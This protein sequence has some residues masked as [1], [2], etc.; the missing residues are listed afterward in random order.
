MQVPIT[1]NAVV[2]GKTITKKAGPS[3]EGCI[4]K[5]EPTKPRVKIIELP[6]RSLIE[7]RLVAIH[8]IISSVAHIAGP[9]AETIHSQ[10]GPS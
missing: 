6:I 4:K 9:K 5:A 8:Q 2:P 1:N 10:A 7:A 3:I